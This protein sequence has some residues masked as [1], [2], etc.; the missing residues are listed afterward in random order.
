MLNP[1]FKGTVTVTT[2]EHDEVVIEARGRQFV[3][4]LLFMNQYA[5]CKCGA[6]RQWDYFFPQVKSEAASLEEPVS[7]EPLNSSEEATL[8][9][10]VAMPAR[11]RRQ[12]AE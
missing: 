12:I 11:K 3:A 8:S 2:N 9:E 10:P 7:D 4:D 6:M 5:L 1:A